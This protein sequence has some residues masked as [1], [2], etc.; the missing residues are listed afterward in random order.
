MSQQQSPAQGTPQGPANAQLLNE[1][2]SEVSS[3]AAPLLEFLVRH[4]I[5]IMAGLVLFVIVLLGYGGYTWYDN[6]K[7]EKA[8]LEL[9]RIVLSNEGAERITA[10]EAFAQDAPDAVKTGTWLALAETAVQLKDYDKAATYFGDIVPMDPQ[11]AIG[12]MAALN[13]GQSLILAKKYA[14]A[15]PVL[16]TLLARVVDNQRLVVRQALA[17]AALL[18]GD[19]AKAKQLFEAMANESTGPEADFFRFRANQLAQQA[20]TK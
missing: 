13:Q 10:L 15:V 7:T 3:E 18:A 1:I 19:T 16:E 2:Q 4:G 12:I 5:S 14:E 11:G 20:T 6:D 9:S 17:E 8:H